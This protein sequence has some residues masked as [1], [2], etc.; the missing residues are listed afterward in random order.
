MPKHFLSLADWPPTT[1]KELIEQ[2]IW[3]KREYRAGGNQ[4]MLHGKAL[5]M[6][7][8]KLS[9][10]TR[11]S[12]EMAMQHLGGHALYI[13]AHEIEMG[14][15][16]SIPDVVRTLGGYVQGILA[17]VHDHADLLQMAEYSPVPII[18]GLSNYS[19]PCQAMA[20]VLTMYEEFGRL[21]GLR[22]VYLGNSAC[23][24]ARS[25]LFA[26]AKFGF[27]LTISGPEQYTL[28]SET[29]HAA[30]AL[31][32]DDV[33][34]LVPDPDE[35]VRDQDV[36]YTDVWV[37]PSMDRVEVEAA[38]PLFPPYQVDEALVAKAAPRAIVLHCLPANRGQ[39]ITDAVAD[40]SHSRLFQQAE[41]RLHAQK[42][43][44]V[45]LLG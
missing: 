5:A 26:A 22:L 8:Q 18:N 36:L 28:D 24:V 10:R 15:R 11:V 1:L 42:A 29:I 30:R 16:E 19:H 12:F 7:F 34:R 13:G 20:D 25:L 21:E 43:I 9:L 4:Y 17:R 31:G 3:L 35:A 6:I 38:L 37:W 14:K 44:L 41:N 32:G 2:A 39:E 40:G 23:D 33:V 45:H 27:Q